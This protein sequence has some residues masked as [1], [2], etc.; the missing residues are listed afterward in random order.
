[1][2]LIENAEGLDIEIISG[3]LQDEFSELV[4]NTKNIVKDCLFVC[5]KGAKFDAHD[6]IDEIVK[7]GAKAV[8]VQKDIK[9]DELCVIQV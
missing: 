4:F 1:M 6:A 2:K 7:Q 5:I 3:E 8:V 9:R